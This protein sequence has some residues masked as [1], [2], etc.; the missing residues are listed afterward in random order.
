MRKLLKHYLKYL[1]CVEGYCPLP[2]KLKKEHQDENYKE[3]ME[4]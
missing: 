4:D 2:R 3:G 1:D